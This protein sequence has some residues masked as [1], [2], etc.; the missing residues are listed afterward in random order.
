MT[1][2]MDSMS[3]N[4]FEYL[5][6]KF[7]KAKTKPDR[8]YYANA[9]FCKEFKAIPVNFSVK[10]LNFL[11]TWTAISHKYSEVTD[12]E[13][14]LIFENAIDNLYSTIRAMFFEQDRLKTNY[15]FQNCLKITEI[16]NKEIQAINE[17]LQS[18][19]IGNDIVLKDLVGGIDEDDEQFEQT[20]DVYSPPNDYHFFETLKRMETING[21]SVK[22]NKG[23]AGF[24][25]LIVDKGIAHFDNVNIQEKALIENRF[26]LFKDNGVSF[27]MR[28]YLYRA[29]LIYMNCL[30]H[31]ADN[32]ICPKYNI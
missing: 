9:L 13:E 20:M 4:S 15:T 5:I 2:T 12:N 29:H 10:F 28:R 16:Y 25:K 27:I 6:N 26:I 23:F 3:N 22:N 18:T 32:V 8:Q 1:I 19:N 14:K 31:Y 11:N 17:I 24:I 30:I 21:K 7:R